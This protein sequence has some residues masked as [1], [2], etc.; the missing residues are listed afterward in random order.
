MSDVN[1]IQK[2]IAKRLRLD[3]CRSGDLSSGAAKAHTPAAEGGVH[4]L[5]LKAGGIAFSVK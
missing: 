1:R 2:K 3:A 5:K 4:R